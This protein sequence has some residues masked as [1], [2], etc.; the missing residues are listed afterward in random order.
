MARMNDV[1]ELKY[2]YE[3]ALREKANLEKRLERKKKM[4]L[5]A[6]GEEDSLKDDISDIDEVI[7]NLRRKYRSFESERTRARHIAD[8][9]EKAPWEN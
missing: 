8:S 3:R 2:E 5:L 4:N 6:P 9:S 7:R 1:E